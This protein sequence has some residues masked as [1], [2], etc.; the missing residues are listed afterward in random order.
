MAQFFRPGANAFFRCAIAG[1]FL[2][3]VGLLVLGD[4]LQK[5]TYVTEVDLPKTQNPPFSHKHHASLGIDCRYCHTSAEESS[6]A[7]IPPTRT[8]MNCHS[9]IWNEAPM[10]EPVRKSWETGEPLK[11]TRVH[12]L[13]EFAY[14]NHSIHV[15]K[16]IGCAT[17][18]GRVD[19]MPLMSRKNTLY[20]GWCLDCHRDPSQF[21]R[22]RELMTKMD[23]APAPAEQASLGAELIQKYHVNTNNYRMLDC[24]NCHR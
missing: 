3:I 21:I 2:S 12:D 8:C 24:N 5:S 13:P 10:L 17:C 18:H 22:P 19:K 23:Y 15:N 16:G 20:M 11:W 4:A 1:G 7:G 6:F 9:M 14:F